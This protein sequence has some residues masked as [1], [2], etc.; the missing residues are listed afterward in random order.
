MDLLNKEIQDKLDKLAKIQESNRKAIKKHLKAKKDNGYIQVSAFITSQNKAKLDLIKQEY[1]HKNYNQTLDLLIDS[2]NLESDIKPIQ[3]NP[4]SDGVNSP[5]NNTL[6]ESITC[7]PEAIE[8]TVI[9]AGANTEVDNSASPI[10][11]NSASQS[12]TDTITELSTSEADNKPIGQHEENSTI[13][14]SNDIGSSPKANTSDISTIS[15]GANK[16]D[17]QRC[18]KLILELKEQKFKQDEIADY[19]NKH[20]WKTEKNKNWNGGN[21]A[22]FIFDYRKDLKQLEVNH[23]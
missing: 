23:E 11:D 19:L 9:I 10:V 13:N 20:G 8:Q 12:G 14:L 21:I 4:Y 18:F 2:F 5:D 7:S 6:S 1:N 22:K 16:F 3:D 15:A 17:K